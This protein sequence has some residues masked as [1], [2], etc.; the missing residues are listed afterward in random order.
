[1]RIRSIRKRRNVPPPAAATKDAEN[2]RGSGAGGPTAGPS[3]PAP[4]EHLEVVLLPEEVCME[5]PHV[6]AG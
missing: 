4:G 5:V 2:P 1:V 6:D 3:K